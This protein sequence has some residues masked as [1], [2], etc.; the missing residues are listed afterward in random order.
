MNRKLLGE[1]LVEAGLITNEQLNH[2]LTMKGQK[3]HLERI[4]RV[5]MNLNYIDEDALIEFLGRQYGTSGINLY[6]GKIDEK[7]VHTITRNVAEKHKV[8]PVGF[9]SDGKTKMLIVA[10]ADPLNLE[11]MDTINFITGYCIE[12][13]FA[14]E[15][16]LRWSIQYYYYYNKRQVV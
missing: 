12:P 14:R 6:K 3:Y 2:A 15:E 7:A 9:K 13:V 16:D 5:L 4:G 8:M 1:S 10:M 11:A